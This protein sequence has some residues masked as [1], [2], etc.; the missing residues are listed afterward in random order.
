MDWNSVLFRLNKLANLVASERKEAGGIGVLHFLSD[1]YV[2]GR[3]ES[4]GFEVRYGGSIEASVSA[5]KFCDVVSTLDAT[6]AYDVSVEHGSF[7]IKG[8]GFEA[9]IQTVEGDASGGR[10]IVK[11]LLDHRDELIGR[12]VSV[13]VRDDLVKI[14]K[15]VAKISSAADG[16]Y[17]SV[18]FDSRG[19]FAT[20]RSRIA[21]CFVQVFDSRDKIVV[22][23]PVLRQVFSVM[24]DETL[25]GAWAVD[26]RLY[27]EF[28]GG[29]YVEVASYNI[30]YPD[31]ANILGKHK[32]K[33]SEIVDVD[34]EVID[35]V[36][37]IVRVLDFSDIV[38]M[39]V[40][41]G[42][43]SLEVE[44]VKGFNIRKD[45]QDVK[46]SGSYRVGMRAKDLDI[47]DG[48]VEFGMSEDVVYFKSREGIEYLV[49]TIA[50]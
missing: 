29:L 33:I 12:K 1:G 24:E 15:K 4:I 37:G 47:V 49:A 41:D 30:D 38:Y 32:S 14:L 34:P 18:C 28:G 23:S 48:I 36:S 9:K 10:R 3:S 40:K 22:P 26:G 20:D 43:L 27:L 25:V 46:I 8:K 17:K 50:K 7:I 13:G 5:S 35:G 16:E 19:V 42:V 31:L 21:C 6:V 11:Y 44:S 39:T 2:W 45:L